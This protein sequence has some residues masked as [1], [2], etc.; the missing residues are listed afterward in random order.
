MPRKKKL[1]LD[2][3][4]TLPAEPEKAAKEEPADVRLMLQHQETGELFAYTPILARRDDMD[5][6]EA[7]RDGTQ[8][9]APKFKVKRKLKKDQ[10]MDVG[11]MSKRDVIAHVFDEYGE[12]ISPQLPHDVVIAQARAI[13][14]AKVGAR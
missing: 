12:R 3:I 7:V 9:K 11:L 6:V 4:E 5:A 14:E 10:L 13:I 8:G 1:S 2:Q